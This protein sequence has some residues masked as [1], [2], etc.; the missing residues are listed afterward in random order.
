VD[1]GIDINTTATIFLKPLSQDD[2][3]AVLN[4]ITVEICRDLAIDPIETLTQAKDF[5]N[6][7]TSMQKWRFAI[8]H[9]EHGLVGGLSFTVFAD[10]QG[11]TTA[12][13]SYWLGEDHRRRGYA[14]KALLQLLYAFFQQGVTHFVAQVYPY[15][16]GS[17]KLLYKLGFSCDQQ[18]MA[19]NIDK[20]VL[21]DFT[22]VINTN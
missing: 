17:Q 21:I 15:N 12:T 19:K 13:F 3:S 2:A 16:I 18:L 20:K 10:D 5:I 1:H 4:L 8:C 14:Y 22:R 11:R 9:H 7:V 6:G